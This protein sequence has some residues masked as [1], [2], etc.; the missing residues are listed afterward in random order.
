MALELKSLSKVDKKTEYTVF[1]FIRQSETEMDKIIPPLISWTCLM[2]YWMN[3]YFEII[4]DT[5]DASKDNSTITATKATQD[6]GN[7]NFCAQRIQSTNEGIYKWTLLMTG[8]D[9]VIGI[10]DADGTK[11]SDAFAWDN[12]ANFYGILCK[13]GYKV[14][15]GKHGTDMAQY[16][17]SIGDTDIIKIIIVQLNTKLK[18]ISFEVNGMDKGVAFEN[19]K[20]GDDIYYRLAVTLE[21]NGNKV[22]LIKY[23]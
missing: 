5:I 13:S 6:W 8:D 15:N 12:D 18:K 4:G 9:I 2:F 1:G 23:E 22:E 3:E 14:W 17:D 19:I 16:Y 10:S 21:E 7:A 11:I 20:C